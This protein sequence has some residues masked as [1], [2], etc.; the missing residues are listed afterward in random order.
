[1]NQQILNKLVELKPVL[2]DRYG[3]EEFAVFGSYARGE[4]NENSDIDITILKIKKV[5][6]FNRV[7]AKYFLEEQLNKRVDLGYFVSI[8]NFLKKRIQK[9]M[10]YV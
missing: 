1:M 3:I 10:I 7:Y 8:R 9:E 5:D 4:E 2:K 6:Y